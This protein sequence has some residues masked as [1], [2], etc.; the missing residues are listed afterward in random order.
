MY[1]INGRCQTR[2]GTFFLLFLLCYS[3]LIFRLP[4]FPPF[5]IANGK[6]ILPF[7]R[8]AIRKKEMP[9]KTQN[10]AKMNMKCKETF[11]RHKNICVVP[12]GTFCISK[13]KTDEVKCGIFEEKIAQNVSKKIKSK[14]KI[15]RKLGKKK[16]NIWICFILSH[17]RFQFVSFT[18]IFSVFFFALEC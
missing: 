5:E 9:K 4:F 15:K 14:M 11:F 13:N 12:F 1:R 8:N 6:N 16:A 10:K 2:L 7:S 18:F 3:F 17:I